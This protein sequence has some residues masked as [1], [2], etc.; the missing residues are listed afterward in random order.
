[1]IPQNKNFHNKT[2]TAVNPLSDQSNFKIKTAKTNSKL[3]P[4]GKPISNSKK[5]PNN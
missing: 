4:M 1:M 3:L 5:F 2:G